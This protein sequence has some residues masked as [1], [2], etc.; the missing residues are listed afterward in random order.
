MTSF[1]NIVEDT[2]QVYNLVDKEV[3]RNNKGVFLIEGNSQR[4]KK[5]CAV[6]V[7]LSLIVRLL[8]ALTFR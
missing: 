7:F 6:G 3:I 2:T 1:A 8:K 4:L 5:C